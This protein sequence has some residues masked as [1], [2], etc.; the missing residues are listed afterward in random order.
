MRVEELMSDAQCC[1]ET[2]TVRDCAKLMRDEDI[3]FVPIC[4]SGNKPIGAITDRDL[5]IRVLAEGRTADEKLGPYF[6]PDIV[7]CRIG[8]DAVDAARLMRERQVSRVIVCDDAGRLKGV[9]GLADV[10][11]MDRDE[12][13]GETVHGL[14]SEQPTA[15]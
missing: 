7:S 13:F 14:K 3:G 10:A 8:D 12:E 5:A 15:H 1:R 9:I 4:D 11:S 6:T 2:D